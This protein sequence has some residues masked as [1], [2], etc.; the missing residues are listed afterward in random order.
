MKTESEQTEER[1]LNNP[2]WYSLVGHH[3][4]LAIG[5]AS[6]KR[7]P[8][9][10]AQYAAFPDGSEPNLAELAKLVEVDELIVTRRFSLP[11]ESGFV[12]EWATD[13]G[14]R[15]F[16]YR[17][18]TISDTID[19]DIVELHE[20]DVP[21]MMQLVKIAQPGQFFPRTIHMGQ[22]AGIRLDGKLIAM[23]GE[24]MHPGQF[25]EISIVCTHP[26]YT[27]KGYATQVMTHLIARILERGETPFLHVK[28]DNDQAIN[29]YRKMGFDWRSDLPGRRGRQG[30][31]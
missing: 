4:A 17:A 22:F 14:I 3:A 8:A 12:T 26:P 18:K 28:A 23:T 21:D 20:A 16:I 9:D 31:H 13:T 11:Q 25:C 29:L 2:M 7:Y 24:R 19:H 6:V 5:G 1:L 30:R 15:Q 10:V 27:R